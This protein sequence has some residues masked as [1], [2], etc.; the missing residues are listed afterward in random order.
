MISDASAVHSPRLDAIRAVRDGTVEYVLS[1]ADF[2]RGDR[3]WPAD[4]AVFATNPMSVAYGASGTVLFL[5][6]AGVDEQALDPILGWMSAAFGCGILPS[7]TS[8]WSL[9]RCL[10]LCGTRVG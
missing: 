2:D 3:L 6:R 8:F 10:Y 7:W 4:P 9:R 5:V 1:T